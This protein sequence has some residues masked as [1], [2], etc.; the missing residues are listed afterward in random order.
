[1]D[2]RSKFWIA[3]VSAAGA[4]LNIWIATNLIHPNG[5]WRGRNDFLGFYAGAC[6]VG[7]PHLY[8]R[9]SVRQEH[10]RAVNMEGEIQFG[11]FPC[12]AFF[13]K[14]LAWL[15]YYRAAAIWE[16]LGGAAFVG[17][18]MLWPG[19]SPARRWPIC[20]WS[21]PAVAAGFGGQDDLI[22]L[23]WVAL[24]ARLLR[25]QKPILAG[26]ILALCSSKFHLFLLVPVVL[27][28][29]GRWRMLSGL[30]AGMAILLAISFAVA[31]PNWPWEFYRTLA[32]ARIS[33]SLANMPNLHSIIRS[34]PLLVAAALAFVAGIFVA[35]RAIRSYE[36]A[37]G[38]AL[39]AGVLIGFH[40]YLA[41]GC[42]FLPGLISLSAAAAAW[43]RWPA[44]IL[45]TPVP[46][47]FTQLP[48]PLPVA[49]VSLLIVATCTGMFF[50]SRTV[51]PAVL[52]P[53]RVSTS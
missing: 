48:E 35:A 3:A 21:L 45:V 7:G 17:F 52:P 53:A 38:V 6:L 41:D 23:L 42:L 11:R 36:L 8:D 28:A 30:V 15:P 26:M 5:D 34:F 10:I 22:L 9:E 39:M 47:A 31:G 24:S 1:M 33:F 51:A 46:W 16:L 25:S 43:V 4:L 37:V 19:G 50:L 2:R 40:G 29:Q 44:L 32:D 18:I 12:F 13:I 49:G 27:L 14:P 20:C